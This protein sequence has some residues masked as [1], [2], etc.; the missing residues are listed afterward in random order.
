MQRLVFNVKGDLRQAAVALESEVYQRA[1]GRTAEQMNQDF[2]PYERSSVVIAVV[3]GDDRVVGVSRLILPSDAGLK[4]LADSFERPDGVTPANAARAAGLD[5]TTT[6]EWATVAVASSSKG[7]GLSVAIALFHGA[8]AA[9]AV[10]GCTALVG[11][12]DEQFL[13][14]LSMM[15]LSFDRLPGVGVGPVGEGGRITPVY[16]RLPMALDAQRRRN[17]DAYRLVTLGIG[18]DGVMLPAS[19]DLLLG[20]SAHERLV[21]GFD[22]TSLEEIWEEFVAAHSAS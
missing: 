20:D 15:D 22:P 4:T 1:F 6:W 7:G 21:G 9:A 18:L 8:L 16:A 3:D 10:N 5:P 17:P 19:S 11:T 2:A 12:F 13:A 14:T